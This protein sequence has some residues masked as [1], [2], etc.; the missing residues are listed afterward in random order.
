[1]LSESITFIMPGEERCGICDVRYKRETAPCTLIIQPR[2]RRRKK[3]STRK[4]LVL[5]C[6]TAMLI[7]D[8][9]FCEAHGEATHE[10]QERMQDTRCMTQKGTYA[11]LYSVLP[12]L[13]PQ[14]NEGTI[15]HL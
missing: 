8:P 13:Q 15:L 2:R 1:M 12:T 3:E 6:H 7:P 10:K 4:G 11:S 14:I 5:T 9:P